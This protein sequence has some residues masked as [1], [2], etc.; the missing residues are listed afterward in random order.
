MKNTF[1]QAVSHDLRTPLAAILGL[2]VTLE[3]ADLEL[4]DE[5]ARDMARRIAVNAR[6]LDRM[7]NDL[8]DLDRLA[9]GI[10]EP[11]RHA[12]DVGDLVSPLVSE[13]DL[14]A[15]GRIEVEA[16][17]RPTSTPR[18]S[19]GSSRTCSRTPCGTR[20]TNAAIWVR[21]RPAPDGRPH[22]GRGR[23]PGR[24]DGHREHD[25]R[26]LPPGPGRP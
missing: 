16:P 24:A 19:S 10:V 4:R 8:L 2:A 6:K 23:R 21:V 13:S 11:K 9:R 26:A 14:A 15:Q 3:R 5:D 12:T 1:L 18:R 7:V 20:R 22:R 17:R 25:L